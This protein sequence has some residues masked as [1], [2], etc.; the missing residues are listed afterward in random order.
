[1]V[2][3]EF[4]NEMVE[5]LREMKGKTFK[6]YEC[7]IDGIAEKY[8]WGTIR[9][10]L[11][12]YA[13]DIINREKPVEYFDSVEGLSGFECQKMNLKDDYNEFVVK[14]SFVYLVDEKIQSVKIVRDRIN[15]N[16]GEYKISFDT[17]V[18]ITTRYNCYTISRGHYFSEEMFF[19]SDKTEMHPYPI[20]RIIDDWNDPE[21]EGTVDVQRRIIEL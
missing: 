7:S 6:S 11:G 17:A 12:Q 8:I 3:M 2:H 21:D 15:I 14:D 20:S 1:M 5:I 10:N 19:L 18:I 16:A 4:S 13:V 9:I